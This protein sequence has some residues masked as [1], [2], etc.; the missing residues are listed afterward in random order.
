[1]GND[2]WSRLAMWYALKYWISRAVLYS[3]VDLNPKFDLN[4]QLINEDKNITII[5][6]SDMINNILKNIK[7]KINFTNNNVC[8]TSNLTLF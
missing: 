7:S 8:Q 4:I 1:M 6:H 2:S 3:D 5:N